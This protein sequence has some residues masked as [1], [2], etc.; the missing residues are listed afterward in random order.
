MQLSNRNQQPLHR[1]ADHDLH[2]ARPP[3]HAHPGWMPS[4][5]QVQSSHNKLPSLPRSVLFGSP[6]LIMLRVVTTNSLP[7]HVH[8]YPQ[9]LLPIPNELGWPELC[10][11][12]LY[13]RMYGKFSAR[14]AVN[15][16][17]RGLARIV[18]QAVYHRKFGGIPAINTVYTAYLCGS[19]QPYVCTLCIHTYVANLTN[20]AQPSQTASTAAHQNRQ[21]L[22][23]WHRCPSKQT[24]AE[25]MAP[26]PIKIDK[27]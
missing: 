8:S 23:L 27:C 22:K 18:K 7:C 2:F 15:I 12:T 24:N 25:L 6:L 16:A 17:A 1:R 13:G 4:P 21:V 9:Q 14:N 26:L 19:G 11:H 3:V 20:D 10:I 5:L